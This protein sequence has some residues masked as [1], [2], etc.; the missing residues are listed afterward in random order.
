MLAAGAAPGETTE[1]MDVG[2]T[3]L[4]RLLVFSIGPRCGTYW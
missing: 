4:Y 3:V 1:L 2:P